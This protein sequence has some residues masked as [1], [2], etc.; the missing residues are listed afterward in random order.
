M[1]TMSKKHKLRDWESAGKLA[2]VRNAVRKALRE[3]S[4]S[5]PVHC[6]QCGKHRS[7]LQQSNG[8]YSSIEGHHHRGYEY[9]HALDVVWLCKKC[10]AQAHVDAFWQDYHARPRL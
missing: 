7:E 3:G 4:L 1:I 10:H 6:S 8:R 2:S 5:R 9:E